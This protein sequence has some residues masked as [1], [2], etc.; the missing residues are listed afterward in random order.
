MG[1]YRKAGLKTII[2][3]IVKFF[4][5]Y[6][7]ISSITSFHFICPRIGIKII[8]NAFNMDF[9]TIF[10]VT[11]RTAIVTQLIVFVIKKLGNKGLGQLS[12]VEL[13]IY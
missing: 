1:R 4:I 9:N 2:I 12:S 6:T 7:T 11:F 13:I 3:L 8:E 10:A 5:Q